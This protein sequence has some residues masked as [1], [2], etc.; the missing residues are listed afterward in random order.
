MITV[1]RHPN[2]DNWLEVRLADKLLDQFTS[3]V[4]AHAFAKSEA[5]KNKTTIRFIDV[6]TKNQKN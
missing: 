4:Q 3:I 5:N 2:L 6:K 1:Q